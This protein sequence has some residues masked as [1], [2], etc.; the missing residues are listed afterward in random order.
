MDLR[1]ITKYAL[2]IITVILGLILKGVIA[3]WI[4]NFYDDGSYLA[5]FIDMMVAVFVFI[6][7]FG[8]VSEYTKKFSKEYLA[9]AKKIGKNRWIGFL[10][11]F[12]IAFLIL[13]IAYAF[14][15]FDVNILKDLGIP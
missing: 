9:Q 10:I 6:P 13:Y 1:I 2:L 14:V 15:K 12:L 11:G 4:K 5:I 3:N 8:I 7:L